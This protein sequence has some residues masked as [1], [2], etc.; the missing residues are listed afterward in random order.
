M[1]EVRHQKLQS[2]VD[3]MLCSDFLDEWSTVTTLY[4][5]GQGWWDSLW[6]HTNACRTVTLSV[7]KLNVVRTA[8]WDRPPTRQGRLMTTALL[9][10]SPGLP[11][12]S[13]SIHPP[14]EPLRQRCLPQAEIM[15]ET[16]VFNHEDNPVSGPSNISGHC[17][18]YGNRCSVSC[19]WCR[20]EASWASFMA[21][22]GSAL[23]LDLGKKLHF[24]LM[25]IKNTIHFK[26]LPEV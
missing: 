2:C 16:T 8:L 4:L 3:V 19:L 1:P 6:R 11:L 14:Q 22:S 12:V 13:T 10:Y 23:L 20:L 5:T 25:W 17:L 15:P 18:M 26:M 24:V 9:P 21:A 7:S